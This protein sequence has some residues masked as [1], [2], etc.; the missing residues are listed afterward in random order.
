M[1]LSTAETELI[2]RAAAGDRDALTEL[3]REFGPRVRGQLTGA[4]DAAWQSQ[5]DIDDVMQVTYLE[6]FLRIDRFTDPAEGAFA[7]WLGQIARNNLRDAIRELGRMKR[8]PAERRVLSLG[9]G[10]SAVALF[11]QLA[12]TTTTASRHA[13]ASE[14]RAIVEDSVNRLPADYASVIRLYDLEGQAALAVAATMN[15]SVGAVHML[16]MRALDRLRETLLA[17]LGSSST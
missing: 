4:I 8:S 13:A 2:R 11:E 5:L 10:E 14:V 7:A 17:R 3:L 1:S 6:A 9:G 16:R 12:G 15:R